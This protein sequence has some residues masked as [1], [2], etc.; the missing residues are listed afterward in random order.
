ML[1]GKW[2]AKTCFMQLLYFS[3]YLPFFKLNLT[4]EIHLALGNLLYTCLL[5]LLLA[6]T[7]NFAN[8]FSILLLLATYLQI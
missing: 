6:I 5:M 8:L 7:Y 4:T 3:K 1:D 2:D